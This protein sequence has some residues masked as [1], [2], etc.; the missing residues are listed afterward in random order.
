MG[1][2]FAAATTLVFVATAC[3]GASAEFSEDDTARLTAACVVAGWGAA[4]C[5]YQVSTIIRASESAAL[6]PSC[7]V[8]IASN[9]YRN[10][11][12]NAF[13]ETMDFVNGVLQSDASCQ[14]G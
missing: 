4:D 1:K 8:D 10:I 5:G 13:E 2:V 3:G 11:P 9:L 14:A 12:S 6:K 7:V